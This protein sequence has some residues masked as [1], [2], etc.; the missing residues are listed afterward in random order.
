MKNNEGEPSILI[1]EGEGEIMSVRWHY[2]VEIYIILCVKRVKKV[3]ILVQ[4]KSNA[5][6]LLKSR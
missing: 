4:S 2:N 6:Y 3:L 1:I 5:S